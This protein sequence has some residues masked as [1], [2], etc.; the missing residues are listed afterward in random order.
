MDLSVRQAGNTKDSRQSEILR[1][2]VEVVARGP[3]KAKVK[4]SL[5]K[6]TSAEV[7][8][9]ALTKVPD[10]VGTILEIAGERI[11]GASP[12]VGK[13]E[14]VFDDT[15]VTK[16]DVVRQ[17]QEGGRFARVGTFVDIVV[18][19]GLLEKAESLFVDPPR[20]TIK[21]GEKTSAFRAILVYNNKSEEDVTRW[22][23]WAVSGVFASLGKV[24][25]DWRG[26]SLSYSAW[27][28]CL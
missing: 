22:V 12:R 13:V 2:L 28:P 10:L 25:P 8:I 27:R 6:S 3:S 23:V 18:S 16:G 17:S 7:K 20:V 21:V 4:T 19:K 9:R 15:D 14:Y 11:A 5:K 24:L 1:N 26:I